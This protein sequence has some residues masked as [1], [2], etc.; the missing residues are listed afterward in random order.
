MKNKIILLLMAC[1]FVA[2]SFTDKQK[3]TLDEDKIQ[4]DGVAYAILEKT[5]PKLGSSFRLKSLEGKDLVDFQFQEYNNP[6]QVSAGNSR[7]RVTYYSVTFL[8]DGQKCEVDFPGTKKMLA[9]MIVENKLVRDNAVD[10]EAEKTFVL[11][12]GSRFT[13]DRNRMNGN[14]IIINR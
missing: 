3:I 1:F 12:N 9:K 7:G 8:N 4:V 13:E 6:N 10:V 14:V 11:I 5:G 2:S